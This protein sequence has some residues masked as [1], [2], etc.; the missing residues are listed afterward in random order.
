MMKW[1]KDRKGRS[2]AGDDTKHY[3]SIVVALVKTLE[4]GEKLD[5]ITHA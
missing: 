2:L 3:Q 5:Q 4:I 1:Q